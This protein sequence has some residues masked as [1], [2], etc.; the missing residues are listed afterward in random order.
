MATIISK[1]SG[2]WLLEAATEGALLAP[3]ASRHRDMMW[4]W[5]SMGFLDQESF[6]A[7][8]RTA[9]K[10]YEWMAS[11]PDSVAAAIYKTYPEVFDDT[12]G[13]TMRKF[14]GSEAGRPYR[15]PGNKVVKA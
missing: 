9:P 12:T 10:G 1:R 4:W 5:G 14:L 7:M 15:V 3:F 11:F 13:K 6:K 2:E 8:L